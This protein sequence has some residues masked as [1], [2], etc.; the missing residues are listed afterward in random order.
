MNI[1][2]MIV[3]FMTFFMLVGAIDKIIGNKFGYAEKFEN[4]FMAMGPLALSMIGAVSLAPVIA[5]ILRPVIVPI[6]TF[7]GADPSIFATTLLASD[8]GGYSLAL[9]LASTKEIGL[10]S[11]LILG[12]I[13][14]PTFCF[15]IP[16]A[17]GIIEKEDHEFLA[18]G[19]LAG[20][21]AVP[22][23][24]FVGGIVAGFSWR[25]LMHN[26]VPIIVVAGLIGIALWKIPEKSIKVFTKFGN[27]VIGLITLGT[28]AIIIETLTGIIL[29]PGMAPISEGI[30]IVGSIAIVLAGAFPMVYFIQ[31]TFKDPIMKVGEFIGIS[32]IAVIGL[33]SSLAHCIPMFGILKD[34]DNKGKILNVAFAVSGAFVFGSHLGFTAGISKDMILPV[35]I[36]KLV[37][38]VSAIFIAYFFI[39]NEN[40]KKIVN[41][42]VKYEI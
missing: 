35:I 2:K 33:L 8:M 19:V 40:N 14:G 25:M 1:E 12:T 38:G 39:P 41:R 31:K 24:S 18:K 15:T 32:H 4:G 36:G 28:A 9:A 34:M 5:R 42:K 16:V 27:F 22:I 21:I 6:Y 10:F 30:K 11:G 3:Y 13:M 23:G 17:L 20:L 37:S 7:L 26:L 29:I